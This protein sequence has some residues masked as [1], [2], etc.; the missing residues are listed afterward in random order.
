MEEMLREGARPDTAALADFFSTLDRLLVDIDTLGRSVETPGGSKLL[1]EL[2]NL[3]RKSDL[4]AKEFL[5][6][7]FSGSNGKQETVFIEKIRS[8]LSRR[9]FDI[10]LEIAEDWRAAAVDLIE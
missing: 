6:E 5:D 10:A 3:I 1:D 7:H 2:E 4:N 8:A 9:D